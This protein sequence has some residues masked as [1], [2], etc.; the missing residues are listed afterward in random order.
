MQHRFFTTFINN[1]VLPIDMKRKLIKQR[2]SYTVTLPKDWISEKNL[3]PGDEIELEIEDGKV[4]IDSKSNPSLKEAEIELEDNSTVRSV[5]GSMYRAGYNI[6]RISFKKKMTIHELQ[7]AVDFF[8][9]LEIEDFSEKKVSLR[10]IIPTDAKEFDFYVKKIFLTIKLMFDEII[11]FL[12]GKPLNFNNIE[13]MRKTNLKAREYCMR[14]TNIEK[15]GKKESC[16]EYTFIHILEKIS[17]KLWHMGQYINNKKIE[18]SPK[19]KELMVFLKD[20][21]DKAYH[22]YLKK[23]KKAA[24]EELLSDRFK[25]RKEWYNQDKLQKFFKTK[26]VDP[27]LLALAFVIRHDIQSA[28]ARFLSTIVE[29]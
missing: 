16:D 19:L 1:L 9:G 21:V 18:R 5:I 6:I 2:D 28:I 8:N 12:E 17:G 15:I 29:Y 4:T 10:C 23:D 25:M 22:V 7:K 27:V 14:A 13:D 24:I 3:K 26:G 11:S 20:M